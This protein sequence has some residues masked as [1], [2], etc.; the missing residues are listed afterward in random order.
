MKRSKPDWPLGIKPTP[1]QQK[2]FCEWVT[3]VDR[4][5]ASNDSSQLAILYA[6]L[7]REFDDQ[8]AS[9]LWLSQMSGWDASAITG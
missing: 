7:T 6:D 5:I 9:Q 8:Q 4:A 2:W 3:D 1:D